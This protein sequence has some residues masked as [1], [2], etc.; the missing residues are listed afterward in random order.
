MAYRTPA[1]GQSCALLATSVVFNPPTPSHTTPH[2]IY[3]VN[4]QCVWGLLGWTNVAEGSQP[5]VRTRGQ[6][7]VQRV[8]N[9]SKYEVYYS[10]IQSFIPLIFAECDD[11]LP[12]PGTSSI[13]L[14]YVLLPST[15]LHQLCFHPLSPHLAIYRLVRNRLTNFKFEYCAGATSCHGWRE[16]ER[17]RRRCHF[18]WSVAMESWNVQQRVTC[19]RSFGH[20]AWPARSPELTVPNF[21]LW[22]FL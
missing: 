15:L 6:F 2:A 9:L 20:I 18:I 4:A 16:G 13:P 1:K 11:S 3:N 5:V 22:G 8:L 14:C 7:I 10:F 17:Q 19:V 12:F 21:F